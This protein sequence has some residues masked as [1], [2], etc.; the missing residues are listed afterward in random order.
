VTAAANAPFAEVVV[1]MHETPSDTTIAIHRGT[2]T[3]KCH[4]SR[5]D[6]FKSINTT[7]IAKIEDRKLTMLAGEYKKRNPHNR[8]VL[9]PEFD[10]RV[11]LVKSHPSMN[12]DI[13]GWYVKNG[14][15][16]IVLEGTGLG[17]IDRRCHDAVRNAVSS[18]LVVAMTSQCIWGRVNMNVYDSGRDLQALG[19][20]PLEDM[21]AETALVKLM[22]TLGQTVNPEEAKKLLTTNIAGELEPRTLLEKTCREGEE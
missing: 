5:R 9:R 18:G 8:L 11:A 22:W 4:T 12:P 15:R 2:K 16:G 13:I 17:H 21:L 7:P 1:A 10:D 20:I 19:V 6:A 3:R 14:Y